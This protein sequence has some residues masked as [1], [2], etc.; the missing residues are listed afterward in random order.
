M[1]LRSTVAIVKMR[2]LRRLSASETFGCLRACSHKHWGRAA[3]TRPNMRDARRSA[4]VHPHKPCNKAGAALPGLPLE[5]FFHDG[6]EGLGRSAALQRLA[7]HQ[8]CCAPAPCIPSP[9]LQ[10]D[11]QALCE[12]ALGSSPV[13]QQA[14]DLLPFHRYAGHINCKIVDARP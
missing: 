4:C 3:L 9:S 10:R 13:I 7:R 12:H 8:P 14:H 2:A 11:P 1:S 6:V 5:I